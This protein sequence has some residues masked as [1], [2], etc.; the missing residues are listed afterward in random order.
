MS[1]TRIQPDPALS[2]LIECYWIVESGDSKVNRE[3]IVPDGFTEVIFH[4]GDS[5]RT[6]INRHWQTQS[7]C[8]LAGQISSYFYLENTG[9][10]GIAAIKFKPAALTQLFGLEMTAYTNKV[11]DL[12][13]TGIE[14]LTGLKAV[15][16]PFKDEHSLARN[17]DTY[18]L[19]LD[20]P[21]SGGAIVT[22]IDH[23][24]ERNGMVS[25]KE[26]AAAAGIGERQL[27]RLFKRYIGLAPKYYARIIRFSYIFQLIKDQ[28]ITWA[29]VVYRS[30]YYDQSH[31]IRDFK[32]F[33]GEDP[34]AYY[35]NED[36]M[37]N[38]FLKK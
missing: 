21:L 15:V 6:N 3:K 20:L 26:I 14:G 37:A 24:F 7:A 2:S 32:A 30:G 12:E 28:Y 18:F 35:F 5:Y 10:A 25:V 22:A 29:E 16:F 11:V 33:A 27:E 8:L 36:N 17:L 4:F 13:T 9:M 34:S 19:S 38:F 23:I 31:F 1:F